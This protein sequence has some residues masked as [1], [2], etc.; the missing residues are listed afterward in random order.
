V[1]EVGEF[2]EEGPEHLLED[3]VEI[4]RGDA[5]VAEPT[6]DEGRVEFH[7]SLP[8]RGVRAEAEAFEQAD[9]GFGHGI[10]IVESGG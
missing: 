7:Q 6:A 5:V 2:P 1:V 8:G 4:D 10:D 9:G 3:V